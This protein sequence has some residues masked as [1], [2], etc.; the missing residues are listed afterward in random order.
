MLPNKPCLEANEAYTGIGTGATGTRVYRGEHSYLDAR[1]F[2][3]LTN[4]AVRQNH[5]IELKDNMMKIL[6]KEASNTQSQSGSKQYNQRYIFARMEKYPSPD[7]WNSVNERTAAIFYTL[8]Y[9]PS[10]TTQR[11]NYWLLA[12]NPYFIQMWKLTDVG[13]THALQYCQKMACD[14]ISSTAFVP[15]LFED[16]TSGQKICVRWGLYAHH[17]R[18]GKLEKYA[19]FWQEAFL[20]EALVPE[21]AQKLCCPNEPQISFL[22]GRAKENCATWM[23]DC[24]NYKYEDGKKDIFG[25]KKGPF[26]NDPNIDD[27]FFDEQQISHSDSLLEKSFTEGAND[28]PTVIS[29]HA[30]LAYMI[31][32][33]KDLNT[34]NAMLDEGN[35]AGLMEEP[36][37]C[38][39]DDYINMMTSCEPF[40]GKEPD[41]T[42]LMGYYF[43]STSQPVANIHN[44]DI[45]EKTGK[46][47]KSRT[48]RYSPKNTCEHIKDSATKIIKR[49]QKINSKYSRPES[50][51]SFFAL[52]YWHFIEKRESVMQMLLN[53][54]MKQ[55]TT[56]KKGNGLVSMMLFDQFATQSE[57]VAKYEPRVCPYTGQ[58]NAV[59][60]NV[61][62]VHLEVHENNC[63]AVRNATRRRRGSKAISGSN[64]LVPDLKFKLVIP[65]NSGTPSVKTVGLPSGSKGPSLCMLDITRF[66]NNL[67]FYDNL[68]IKAINYKLGQLIAESKVMNNEQHIYS[69]SDDCRLSIRPQQLVHI[70]FNNHGKILYITDSKNNTVNVLSNKWQLSN[71]K[72]VSGMQPLRNPVD[73]HF[74]VSRGLLPHSWNPFNFLFNFRSILVKILSSQGANCDAL[75]DN[76]MAIHAMNSC[77]DNQGGGLSIAIDPD[78]LNA[79]E[80]RV[81]IKATSFE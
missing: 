11:G 48:N 54:K 25:N 3:W 71:S 51:L 74:A 39:F 20:E 47:F 67:S 77:D 62:G 32:C 68:P 7:V 66:S 79:Y 59:V 17:V 73:V 81:G 34:Y 46:K 42:R 27:D 45:D 49:L 50:V 70:K 63:K 43:A 30:E 6:F 19:K 21:I 1:Y 24:S 60:N 76:L 8:A 78:T 80:D 15:K 13:K 64:I 75:D 26:S 36:E 61:V 38:T 4:M 2:H 41:Y 16:E 5:F 22:R 69:S 12:R 9:L 55:E 10:V 18:E 72:G 52:T 53:M 35:R 56:K 37:G 57:V 33:M 14:P 58:L 29:V 28:P 23:Y 44:C 40:D 65:D 31:A